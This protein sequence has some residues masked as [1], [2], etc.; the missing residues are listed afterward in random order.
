MLHSCA[1]DCKREETEMAFT[2][3]RR[4]RSAVP[5]I[6]AAHFI[7]LTGTAG[8]ST[9]ILVPLTSVA[10]KTKKPQPSV[11]RTTRGYQRKRDLSPEKAQ[12]YHLFVTYILRR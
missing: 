12:T 6:R 7:H 8:I 1:A 5:Y 4:K 2:D 11:L 3:V 9:L 10:E